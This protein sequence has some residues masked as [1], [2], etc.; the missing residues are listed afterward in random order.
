MRR[1]RAKK[2]IA[3]KRNMWMRVSSMSRQRAL[4]G[5]PRGCKINELTVTLQHARA[6]TPLT[7]PPPPPPPPPPPKPPE[8]GIKSYISKQAR[9]GERMREARGRE[10]EFRGEGRVEWLR[11]LD[12]FFF[13][14]RTESGCWVAV[15]FGCDVER[16]RFGVLEHDFLIV[17]IL[18]F[19][20]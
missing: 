15:G 1:A 7:S 2:K 10:R 16:N 12:R 8:P 11:F 4:L 13:S 14:V 17:M 18:L 5:R 6:P 19:M 3:A 9:D 20:G